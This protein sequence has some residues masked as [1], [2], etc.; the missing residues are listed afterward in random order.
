MDCV[1]ELAAFGE[2]R[3]LGFLPSRICLVGT[4]VPTEAS[5]LAELLSS[6]S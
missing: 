6:S 4:E 3:R 1:K 2:L 5:R